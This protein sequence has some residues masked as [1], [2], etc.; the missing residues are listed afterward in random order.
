MR[1]FLGKY[2]WLKSATAPNSTNSSSTF[3][4]P[5]SLAS[6]HTPTPH[7]AATT[8][9]SL[10]WAWP[11]LSSSAC[12]LVMFMSMVSCRLPQLRCFRVADGHAPE[13]SIEAYILHAHSYPTSYLWNI[14]VLSQWA[15]WSNCCS[16]VPRSSLTCLRTEPLVAVVAL[17]NQLHGNLPHAAPGRED[18]K[19]FS[20]W[21]WWAGVTLH[22]RREHWGPERQSFIPNSTCSTTSNMRDR[23]L[24]SPNSKPGA[25]FLCQALLPVSFLLVLLFHKQQ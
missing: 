14:A 6:L 24:S 9:P 21:L 15:P 2:R 1:G 8:S 19:Q 16:C 10:P 25:Y 4:L 12:L 20:S 3:Y 7:Q 13:T 17:E 23:D 22:L 5:Y 18:F 11:N